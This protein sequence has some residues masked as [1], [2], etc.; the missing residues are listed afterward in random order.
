MLTENGVAVSVACQA[1]GPSR[2]SFYYR[3]QAKDDNGLKGAIQEIAVTYL[4]YG[5]RRIIAQL[6]R[7]PY[8]LHVNRKR[9]RR[10][11]WE[12]GLVVKP[13]RKRVSTRKGQGV[14]HWILQVTG[15]VK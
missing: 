1:V 2:S 12:L 9:V 11:M 4:T 5:S 10:L 3:P 8:W 14:Y 6:R 7:G 13:K 15:P